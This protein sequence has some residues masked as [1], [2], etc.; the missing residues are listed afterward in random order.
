MTNSDSAV[1]QTILYLR[2]QTA[3]AIEVLDILANESYRFEVAPPPQPVDIPVGNVPELSPTAHLSPKCNALHDH[4]RV[5]RESTPGLYP[6]FPRV[7]RLG[8]KSV[9]IPSPRGFE[10]GS[11]SSSDIQIPYYSSNPSRKAIKAYFRIHY[12]F[13]SGAL[14]VT[15]LDKI[16]VGSARLGKHESLLLMAGTSIHCGR[17][18]EFVVEF[19]NT[20][21]CAEEHEQNYQQYAVKLGFPD[22]QYLP[23]PRA[24]YPPIGAEHRSVAIIGEGSFGEV[25]RALNIKTAKQAA[26]KILHTGGERE[27]DEVN[28]MSSLSHVS[29]FVPALYILI[30]G[31][32]NIIK[33]ERAFKV[34]AGKTCIVMELAVNDLLTHL[35]ARQNGKR[36]S[37]LSLQCIRSICQQAL[38][39]LDYLHR[40]GIM[41]RDL[42]PQN[43][44]VTKWDTGTDTPT[45]KLADFGLAGIGSKHETFCGTEGYIAP[46]VIRA[47]ER[48][49]ELKKRKNKG[50]KTVPDNQ[51]LMYTNAIDIWALGKILQELV[52]NVPLVLRGKTIPI[53]REPALRLIHRMVQ[54]DPGRRPTAAECLKDPWMATINHSDSLLGQKRDRS[55][56][57]IPSPSSSVGQPLRKVVRK[58]FGEHAATDDGSSIHIMNAIWPNE[59]SEHQ[60]YS[61]QAPFCGSISDVKMNSHPLVQD[62]QLLHDHPPATQL[63]TQLRGDGRLSLTTHGHNEALILDPLIARDESIPLAV[64]ANNADLQGA[65]SSIQDVARRLLAAL[66]AEGYCNNVTIAGNNADLGAIRNE[67]SRLNISSI[68]IRQESE[69]SLLLRLEFDNEERTSNFRNEGQSPVDRSFGP[70]SAGPPNRNS[71]SAA[72][73][74]SRSHSCLQVLFSQAHPASFLEEP[75]VHREESIGAFDQFSMPTIAL[76]DD[77]ITEK[78][79]SVTPAS[80]TSIGSGSS[81][82]SKIDK[83]VTYPSYHD[84]IMAG[85]SFP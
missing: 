36:T 10:F 18:F 73:N 38:S 76:N 48:A 56:S 68:Q 69:S 7:L 5:S 6:I 4:G 9:K 8:F 41:H 85:I 80:I 21:N 66:Q 63:N 35:K 23:T 16:K 53:N 19:P 82:S 12:N 11:E 81:L 14:L 44:L 50:M 65:P 64:L 39:A 52:R 28:I 79:L 34:P 20:S 71:I 74:A 45:I 32:E 70:Q 15:A 17:K 72:E 67:V 26:I 25:H 24:E 58:A 42:K 60:N 51:G 59:R 40:E 29:Q 62:R 1:S 49:K 13:S 55:P 31:K 3:E 30:F 2:P 27:M 84:D 22:P 77:A 33:Y 78:N 43:I 57:S 46:E 61:T 75:W 83:G 54:N 37:Y 47:Y